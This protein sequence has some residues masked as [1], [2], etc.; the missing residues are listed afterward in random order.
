VPTANS[1]TVRW[2]TGALLAWGVAVAAYVT[3]RVNFDRAPVIHVRW[4]PTVTDRI[5]ARLEK[6]FDLAGAE[7]ESGRTWVY[8]L[9]SPSSSNIRDLVKHP[10]VEDTHYVDRLSFSVSPSAE[11]RGPYITAGPWRWIPGLLYA[12][13]VALFIAGAV[14]LSVAIAPAAASGVVAVFSPARAELIS[15]TSR[16]AARRDLLVLGGALVLVWVYYV[17]QLREAAEE[18]AAF[19]VGDWLVSYGTGFVRRGLPGSAILAAATSLHAAPEK[20]VLWVQ[21]ALYTLFS[22]LLFALARRRRLNVWFLVFL[23]SPAGLL[24][25]IYDPAVIGRKDVLFFAV[26]AFYAWWMPRPDR[27]WASVVAF[28]LGAATTLTHELFFFY[29]PYFLV[30]RLVHQRDSPLRRFAPELSLCAGSLIALL[31]ASTVGADLHGEAQCS[32]LL[33]RGFDEELCNGIMRY[34]AMTIADSIDE[35][36]LTVRTQ[37]YLIAYPVAALLGALPLTILFASSRTM[38]HRLTRNVVLSIAG[39]LVFTL[40]MFGIALDWGRLLNIH[41]MA[42]AVI[43]VGF[44]L[45]DVT[46]PASQF[47]VTNGWLRA[48]AFLAIGVYLTAWSIRH[49]CDDPFRAGLFSTASNGGHVSPNTILSSDSPAGGVRSCSF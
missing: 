1:R 8:F 30:M 2:L 47:G 42:I 22:V 18:S 15:V 20:V 48:A 44:L 29:T 36:A 19:R 24:F 12:L 40:P 6:R 28:A 9:R 34:P 21:A 43:V 39:A 31:L 33:Q 13:T 5:R 27:P 17:V 38:R 35:T 3:L 46:T 25:P 37:P 4:A 45:D 11:R 26:F 10:G 23:F 32:A 41:L 16:T 7:Q 49:C 14:A